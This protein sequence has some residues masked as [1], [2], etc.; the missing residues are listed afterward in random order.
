MTQD[1]IFSSWSKDGPKLSTDPTSPMRD[2]GNLEDAI[3]STLKKSVVVQVA[4]L[5]RTLLLRNI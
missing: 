5:I 1:R 4:I 2:I 3:T